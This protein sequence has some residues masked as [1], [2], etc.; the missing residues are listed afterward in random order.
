MTTLYN[1]AYA[2]WWSDPQPMNKD[3]SFR[4]IYPVPFWSSTTGQVLKY[5][6][7]AAVVGV[8]TYFTVGA[9]AM[10]AAVALTE[11]ATPSLAGLLW[12]L[13]TGNITV[14]IDIATFVWNYVAVKSIIGGTFAIIAGITALCAV[15]DLAIA[16]AIHLA[17]DYAVDQVPTGTHQNELDLIKPAVFYGLTSDVV[18]DDLKEL[19]SA[20]KDFSKKPEKTQAQNIVSLMEKID[21]RLST[22]E[23]YKNADDTTAYNY[24]LMAIIR[25]DLEKFES[26]KEALNQARKYTAPDKTSV[27]DYIDALLALQNNDERKAIQLLQHISAGEPKVAVPYIVLAQIYTKHQNYDEAFRALDRGIKNSKEEKCVMNWMAGNCLY[28]LER[29][30]EAIPYCKTALSN[31]Q[32]NEYEAIYKLC[33]AKCYR[34]MD[35]TKNGIYWLNDAVSEVKDNREMVQELERQ[36]FYDR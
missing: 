11:A 23:R 20:L 36:Y 16:G 17:L 35:D 34:K 22:S 27:L 1:K 3:L 8:I 15:G 9:G 2:W 30:E 24:L 5:T 31:M 4:T 29:Y 33:I 6:G 19:K 14:V 7:I 18:K 10:S 28:N 25:Y 12:S 13:L 32:I 21:N 26:A